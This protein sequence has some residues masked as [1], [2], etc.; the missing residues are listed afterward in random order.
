MGLMFITFLWCDVH[1]AVTVKIT[2]LSDPEEGD[3]VLL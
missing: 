1:R 2:V 3:S